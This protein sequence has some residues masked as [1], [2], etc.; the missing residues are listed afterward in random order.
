MPTTQEKADF[1]ARLK[2]ALVESDHSVQGSMDLARLL[3]LWL[4]TESGIGISVQTAHKWLNS[5]AMP[6]AD[7]MKALAQWL[8]V[9]ERWIHYGSS[10]GAMPQNAE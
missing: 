1:S 7:Q 9:S 3:N 6:T 4:C 10:D 8:N 5:R 2:R